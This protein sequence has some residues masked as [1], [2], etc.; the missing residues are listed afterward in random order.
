MEQIL[1]KIEDIIPELREQELEFDF[2]LEFGQQEAM[3]I[4]G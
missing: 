1:D 4:G 3:E 2:D